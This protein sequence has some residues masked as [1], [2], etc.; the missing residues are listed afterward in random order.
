MKNMKLRGI[1]LAILGP[2]LWGIS[3]TVAQF[4]FKDIHVS[5]H[6]LVSVRMLISGIL[7]VIYGML[8]NRSA[9]MAVWHHKKDSMSLIFFSFVGMAASQ[10][11]YFMAIEA[12]NVATAT[13]LQF[14]SPAIIIIY[15]ALWT[16]RFP[17]RIDVL[18]VIMALLGTIL[19]VTHGRLTTLTMPL[20]GFLWGLGAAVSSTLYT[21]LPR[22]LLKKYGSIPI[23]GWSMLIGGVSFS[24]YYKIWD[25][26][27]AFSWTTY[28]SIG[29]VVIFG[30]ML[31][32]LFY[33]QSLR[34]ITP[35]TASVLGSFEPLSATFLSIVFL[36]VSFGLPE[37]FGAVLILGTV[38]VQAWAAYTTNPNTSV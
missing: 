27:P 35:T 38:G 11:T 15:L 14:L 6:W 12:G 30:K 29:F 24:I 32:Y 19:L 25:D 16:R 4:L 13:I 28:G 26:M 34:F 5:S 7:L 9:E 17:R 20:G 10:Y 36:G 3:G 18:S 22:Y 21:L 33:L 31:A 2:L 1:M 23:V 8:G 37:T